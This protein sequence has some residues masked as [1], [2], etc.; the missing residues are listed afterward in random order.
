MLQKNQSQVKLST[1]RAMS[2]DRSHAITSKG[3]EVFMWKRYH[4]LVLGLITVGYL[5]TTPMP[6]QPAPFPAPPGSDPHAPGHAPRIP[7]LP[8]ND[9]KPPMPRIPELK[10]APLPAPEPLKNI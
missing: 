10:P 9:D 8:K 2:L 1:D 7:D 5:V 4:N 6:G 3:E